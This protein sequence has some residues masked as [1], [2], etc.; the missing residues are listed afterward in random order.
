[1]RQVNFMNVSAK[2]GY[3]CLRHLV[4][5]LFQMQPP[6]QGD[7]GVEATARPEGLEGCASPPMDPPRWS[8]DMHRVTHGTWPTQICASVRKPIADVTCGMKISRFRTLTELGVF[9]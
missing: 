8:Q 1:M 9:G 7:D 2:S 6:S 3:S 4:L 5:I